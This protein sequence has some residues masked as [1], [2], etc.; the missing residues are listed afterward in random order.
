M[1]IRDRYYFA[2]GEVYQSIGEMNLSYFDYARAVQLQSTYLGLM[3][4][5]SEDPQGAIAIYTRMIEELPNKPEPYVYRGEVYAGIGNYQKAIDDFEVALRIS[6]SSQMAYEGRAKA[7]SEMGYLEA[8][9]QDYDCLL[10]TSPSPRDR[11]RSRMPSS[12]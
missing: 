12:A 9:L 1:C 8:A 11:T 3:A 2:R 6:S 4:D 5:G 10:Y 7:Y